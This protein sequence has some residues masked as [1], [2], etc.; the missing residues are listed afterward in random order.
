REPGVIAFSGATNSTA[1]RITTLVASPTCDATHCRVWAGAA[2]GGIWRSDNAVAA[3]P[4]WQLVGP[5]DLEQNS[6]GTLTLDPSDA[7]GETLYLG[8]GEANRCSSGCE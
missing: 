1:S 4:D 2:G 5:T 8:T 7:T 6:V 3:N